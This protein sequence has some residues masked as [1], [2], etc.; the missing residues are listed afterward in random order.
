MAA[1][2]WTLIISFALAFIVSLYCECKRTYKD[3]REQESWIRE[4]LE[5]ERRKRGK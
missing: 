4:R 2:I 3:D 1:V 5:K